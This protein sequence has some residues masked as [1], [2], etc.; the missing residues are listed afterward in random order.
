MKN[1]PMVMLAILSATL[2]SGDIVS[3]CSMPSATA[4]PVRNL[5][6]PKEKTMR[7]SGYDYELPEWWDSVNVTGKEAIYEFKY[8]PDPTEWLANM[9]EWG[10]KEKERTPRE[11]LKIR[12]LA[13]KDRKDL[14]VFLA[15]YH[16][17]AKELGP[18]AKIFAGLYALADSQGDKKNWYQCYLAHNAGDCCF[19]L[20]DYESAALW[21]RRAAAFDGNEDKAISYYA[22]LSSDMVETCDRSAAIVRARQKK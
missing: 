3:V 19:W 20:K 17:A 6:G 16:K 2:L 11:H 14:P 12:A 4:A 22:K 13:W 8:S 9:R 18:A 10:E 5:R 1:L 7:I 15:N 21:H